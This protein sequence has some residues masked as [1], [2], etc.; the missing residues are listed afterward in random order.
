CQA[1]SLTLREH[2]STCPIFGVHYCIQVLADLVIACG[3]AVIW[4]VMDA[5]ERRINAWPYLLL[6]LFLG[7]IGPLAYLLKREW[8]A[9]RVGNPGLQ[10]L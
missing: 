10:Q 9:H 5:R 7:S 2:L 6:T 3:L 1:G 8:S 4:V